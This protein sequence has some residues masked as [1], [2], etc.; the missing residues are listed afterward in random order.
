MIIVATTLTIFRQNC[1]AR[2]EKLLAT[3][4]QKLRDTTKTVRTYRVRSVPT[5]TYR[6]NRMGALD[7][8]QALLLICLHKL[9]ARKRRSRGR[10]V[11]HAPNGHHGDI[12]HIKPLGRTRRAVQLN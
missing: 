9:T 1:G 12:L 10:P 8:H 11:A 3:G 2:F 7:R 4:R 5:G 6:E